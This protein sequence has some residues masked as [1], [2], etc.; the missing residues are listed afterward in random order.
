MTK[1][2]QETKETSE[3][4]LRIGDLCK[5]FCISSRVFFEYVS[6]Q[7]NLWNVASVIQKVQSGHIQK[8]SDNVV[9]PKTPLSMHSLVFDLIQVF[10]L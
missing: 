10:I 7:N 1:T 8:S 5:C 3:N 2:E 9:L 6:F 4:I